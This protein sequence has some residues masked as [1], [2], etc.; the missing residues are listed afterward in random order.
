MSQK[1]IDYEYE[2]GCKIIV[3]ED[4]KGGDNWQ[5]F[6]SSCPKHDKLPEDDF[7]VRN[8]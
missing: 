5:R 4:E 8:K 6:E 2:C 1:E 3:Y 7:Y